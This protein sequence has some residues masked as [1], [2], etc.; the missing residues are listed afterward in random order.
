MRRGIVHFVAG[1]NAGDGNAFAHF[2]PLGQ[3]ELVRHFRIALVRP[4]GDAGSA[5]V[6]LGRRGGLQFIFPLVDNGFLD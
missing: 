3:V 6:G 2:M 5:L 1:G 4:H